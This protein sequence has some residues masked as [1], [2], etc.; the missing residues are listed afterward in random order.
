MEKIF[1]ANGAPKQAGVAILISDEEGFKP[2]LVRRDKEGHFMLIKVTIH[3]EDIKI[4]NKYTLNI[5]TPN[6]IKQILLHKKAR[7][8][9]NTIIVGDFNISLSPIDGHPKKNQ[10]RNF[11]IR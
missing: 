9:P 4:I 10:Q 2:K 7:R 3:Q 1:Q 6:F 8:D 5:A 11:R